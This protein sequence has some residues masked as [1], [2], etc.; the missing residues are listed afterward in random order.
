MIGEQ[1][2]M[3]ADDQPGFFQPRRLF[4][5]LGKLNQQTVAQIFCRDADRV[6]ALDTL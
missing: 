3:I 2:E 4:S 6:K 5:I 1:I